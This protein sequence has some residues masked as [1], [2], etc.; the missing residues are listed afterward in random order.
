MTRRVRSIAGLCAFLALTFSFAESVWASTCAMPVAEGMAEMQDSAAENPSD[1]HCATHE[2]HRGERDGSDDPPCPFSSGVAAQACAGV[3]SLPAIN[4]AL[5]APASEAV[6]GLF[7][8][9]AHPGLL[10]E[11]SLFRPPRA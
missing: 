10:L 1:S 11:T 4:A 9:E 6:A 2:G 5:P 7:M 3:V 8:V